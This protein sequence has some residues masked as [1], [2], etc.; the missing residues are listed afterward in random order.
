MEYIGKHAYCF[1][2]IRG[3]LPQWVCLILWYH[4]ERNKAKNPGKAALKLFLTILVASFDASSAFSETSVL[5]LL[6]LDR[7]AR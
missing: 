5:P 6:D 1:T 3:F 4:F 7:L 2:F